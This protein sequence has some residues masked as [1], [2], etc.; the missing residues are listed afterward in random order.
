ME[1]PGEAEKWQLT[2]RLHGAAD[3]MLLFRS[4]LLRL[5]RPL[6]PV[7]TIPSLQHSPSRGASFCFLPHCLSNS[8]VYS[9]ASLQQPAPCSFSLP[10]NFLL[11]FSSALLG[12]TN[13]ISI[14]HIFFLFTALNT[15]LN[16]SP[17]FSHFSSTYFHPDT[18]TSL[19]S[20]TSNTMLSYRTGCFP[21]SDS[22]QAAVRPPGHKSLFLW[23]RSFPMHLTFVTIYHIN[24][25]DYTLH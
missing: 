21:G 1:K 6:C 11:S 7:P 19:T 8:R 9:C 22:P 17:L 10:S 4:P 13:N 18:S 14:F 2:W 24:T 16:H 15:F 20:L 25:Y 5:T 23:S 3:D 12:S